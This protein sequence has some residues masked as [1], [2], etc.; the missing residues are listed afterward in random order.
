MAGDQAVIDAAFE[1]FRESGFRFR[2]LVIALVTSDLFLQK[3][4]R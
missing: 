3:G 1:K 2:E 4:L